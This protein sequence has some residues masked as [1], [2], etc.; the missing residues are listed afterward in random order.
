[1][2]TVNYQRADYAVYWAMREQLTPRQ[3]GEVTAMESK[4]C[5]YVWGYEDAKGE[6]VREFSASWDFSILYAM[7]WARF[8]R[9]EVT[10]L[11][12]IQDAWQTWLAGG[13]I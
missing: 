12:P 11:A 6:R 9:E 1:M 13:Q 3:Q 8:L 7:A 4:A 10:H 5:G 2:E